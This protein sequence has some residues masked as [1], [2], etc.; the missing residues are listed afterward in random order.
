MHRLGVL[1]APRRTML[2]SA[3]YVQPEWQAEMPLVGIGGT[4]LFVSSLAY[5]LNLV[6]TLAASRDPAPAV[7][8][9]AEALSGADHAPA[10]LDR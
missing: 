5:F 8:E 6:L 10:V 9:F 7:P 3:A 4:I 2:G 1:G